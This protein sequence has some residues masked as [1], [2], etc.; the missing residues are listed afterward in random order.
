LA[1]VSLGNFHSRTWLQ[2]FIEVT[3]LGREGGVGCQNLVLSM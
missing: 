1:S 2:T 3:S